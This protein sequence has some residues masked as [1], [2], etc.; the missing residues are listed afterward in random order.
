MDDDQSKKQSLK[1]KIEST[2]SKF[3]DTVQKGQKSNDTSQSR[4][5]SKLSLLSGFFN[6]MGVGLLLG[7]LLGLAVSPVVSGIIGTLSSLLVVLLGLNEN[8]LNPVKSIRI[9]SFGLFCVVGILSGKYLVNNNSFAPSLEKFYNEYREIGF[10]DTVARDLIAYQK[11]RLIPEGFQFAI[12]E[13]TDS[14]MDQQF[15]SSRTVMFSSEINA[16]QC[17]ILK[18]SNEAMNFADLTHN[19]VLAG[20]TWKELANDLDPALPEKSRAKTL[21]LLRDIFCESEGTGTIKVQYSTAM[22]E[23]SADDNIEKIRKTILSDG[24]AIWSKIVAEIDTRIDPADHLRVY[25]SLINIL[26]HD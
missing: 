3:T 24:G 21:L 15:Q 22:Q 1:S 19:F 9:G 7:L 13:G 26:C 8:Y 11:F 17:I 18:S 23:L 12:P 10:S 4:D 2:V 25:L 5:Y 16:S 14:L 20:G 6:G